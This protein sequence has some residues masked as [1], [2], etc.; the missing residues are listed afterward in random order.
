MSETLALLGGTPVGKIKE[1]Q[2]PVFTPEAI[3]RVTA[4]LEAG[5]T[6]GLGRTHSVIVDAENAISKYHGGRHAFAVSSGQSAL[7]AALMGLELGPGDEIIT[8]PYTW[9]ATVSAILAVGAIPIFADVDPETGNLDPA[10]LAEVVSPRTKAIMVVHL[11][12]QP[13]D[14]P[15]INAVARQ[16]H[17]KVIEDASQAH[18]ARI[19]GEVVGNFSDVAA[20]SCMGWKLLGLAEAGYMVTPHEEVFWKACMNGQ[21]YGR[22]GEET[23]PEHLKPYVDSLVFTFRLSPMVAALF[24]SQIEKLDREIAARRENAAY[25]R[26]AMEGVTL[27]CLPNYPDWSAPSYHILPLNFNLNLGVRRDSVFQALRAEGVGIGPYV[28]LPI[29]TWLRLIWQEYDGPTVYWQRHLAQ[30]G[31]DYRDIRLPGVERKIERDMLISWNFTT[32]NPEAM[33]RMARAF[34]KVEAQLPAL[35]EW[36]RTHQPDEDPPAV[37][38][39]KRAIESH[40]IRPA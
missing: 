38:A 8:P 22:G 12:G 14:M 30:S 6:V 40:R 2:H 29:Y 39:A 37:R 31:V 18:G 24:P 28:P 20:F 4:L 23:F 3:A 34:R 21:H 13:A 9:G 19:N 26:Q 5:D 33:E 36:E 32:P 25:F 15:A 11:Y 16:H 1:N 7:M 17:L 27:A 10:R 35:R